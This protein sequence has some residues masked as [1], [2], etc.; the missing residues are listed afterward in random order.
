[1]FSQAMISP[2]TLKPEQLGGQGVFLLENELYPY[3]QTGSQIRLYQ[4]NMKR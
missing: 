1:M 3:F 2:T 4:T